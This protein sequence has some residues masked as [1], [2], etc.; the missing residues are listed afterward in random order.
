MNHQ[1]DS[2]VIFTFLYLRHRFGIA[3]YLNRIEKD[4]QV[5]PTNHGILN[6]LYFRIYFID[7]DGGS[8]E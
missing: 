6:F 1:A 2:Y 8:H 3:Q 4:I 5:F 7:G